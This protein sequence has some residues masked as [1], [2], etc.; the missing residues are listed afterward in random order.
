MFF[1][2]ALPLPV[3]PPTFD[4]LVLAYH[5]ATMDDRWLSPICIQRV[6]TGVIGWSA[7]EAL[8]LQGERALRD[9]RALLEPVHGRFTE[10]FET[11]DWRT[12]SLLLE[13]L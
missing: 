1:S 6:A 10:G 7:A 12:G 4:S 2:A 3:L 11:A 9:A 5:L 13:L 8:R